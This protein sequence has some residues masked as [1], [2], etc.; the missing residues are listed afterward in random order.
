MSFIS[1]F[2]VLGREYDRAIQ[3]HIQPELPELLIWLRR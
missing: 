1:V 3:V 2:D